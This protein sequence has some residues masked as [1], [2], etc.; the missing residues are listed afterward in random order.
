MKSV[1]LGDVVAVRSSLVDPREDKY[2]VLPHIAPDTIERGTGRLFPYKTIGESGVQS[3][4]YRFEAGDVLYSKIRP[5]LNKVALVNFEGLCSADMYALEVDSMKTSAA[6]LQHLLR[7]PL[8]VN[9]ATNLSSRANIPKLNR[10]QLLRF[11]FDLPPLGEQRRIAEILDRADALREMRNEVVAQFENLAEAVFNSAFGTELRNP[12]TTLGEVADIASGITK[13]RKTAEPTRLTPYL[14][15]ANVQAGH[16]NLGQVKEIEATDREIE[17]YAL[18]AGDIVLTEGGD[19]DKLGR[20]TVW[21]EE[22]P[23]CLHQ[24]HIFRVRMRDDQLRPDYL[25]AYLASNPAKSYF[26]RSAK[27]T[28]GIASI[29]MSQLRGTPIYVPSQ[30]EQERYS[31]GINEIRSLQR[32]AVS[33]AASLDELFASLQSRAFASQL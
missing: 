32:T 2:S 4:K 24:N 8:F 23:L 13:G 11:P 1:V 12:T 18:A 31:T 15:V 21:R 3:G 30:S 29:N 17:R 26:L 7:S 27:Q 14:A 9:Y 19:P 28:T 6:F 5:N 10:V 33:K 16:L 22:L 25:S 20:G